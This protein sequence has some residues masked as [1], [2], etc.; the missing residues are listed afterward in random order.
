MQA[1]D[2]GGKE[3][4]RRGTR[5]GVRTPNFRGHREGD[6]TLDEENHFTMKKGDYLGRQ[7]VPTRHCPL[8]GSA[9]L[10]ASSHGIV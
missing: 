5:W 8:D 7:T 3:R 2:E 4:G 6:S 9:Y 10:S 1:V